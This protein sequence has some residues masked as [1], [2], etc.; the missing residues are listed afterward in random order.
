MPKDPEV[1]LFYSGGSHKSGSPFFDAYHGGDGIVTWLIIGTLALLVMLAA[2]PLLHGRMPS[3][4]GPFA[5][6]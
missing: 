6:D 4:T 3:S 1:S 5:K 2:A